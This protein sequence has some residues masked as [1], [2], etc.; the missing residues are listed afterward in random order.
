MRGWEVV[1]LMRGAGV[2]VRS[3]ARRS[4]ATASSV[5]L[6]SLVACG[7]AV[8]Y[9]GDAVCRQVVWA[10]ADI[11]A[12]ASLLRGCVDAAMC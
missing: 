2:V 3:K 1:G 12:P 5:F 8:S 11:F 7:Y 10:D 4:Q 9:A 6:G